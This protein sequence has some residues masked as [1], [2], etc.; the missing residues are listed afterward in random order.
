M[1]EKKKKELSAPTWRS[2]TGLVCGIVGFA[3]FWCYGLGQLLGTI[4]IVFS[5]L[6]IQKQERLA[7][8]GLVLGILSWAVMILLIVGIMIYVGAN[9]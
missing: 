3:L 7:K 4:A 1:N 8:V 2:I 5:A 9:M 6:G